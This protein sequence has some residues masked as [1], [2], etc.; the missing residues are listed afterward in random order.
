[1]R[2]NS[3]FPYS[4]NVN[5]QATVNVGQGFQAGDLFKF[6]S[7]GSAIIMYTSYVMSTVEWF[8]EGF[9][10]Q[11]TLS[12]APS[13][14]YTYIGTAKSTNYA[15][16]ISELDSADPNPLAFTTNFAI[17]MSYQHTLFNIQSVGGEDLNPGEQY[18][19][20]DYFELVVYQEDFATQPDQEHHYLTTV[21]TPENTFNFIEGQ[22]KSTDP[23]IWATIA[24]SSL[25]RGYDWETIDPLLGSPRTHT[26]LIIYQIYY[27]FDVNVQQNG[28]WYDVE[29]G[30]DIEM[31]DTWQ[32][33]TVTTT[34]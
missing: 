4:T 13:N 17:K 7:P 5:G 27:T 34:Y 2:T 31:F 12:D 9:E 3:E 28:E 25:N 30:T 10:Y 23:N 18:Q 29:E 6:V 16:D 15:T 22:S 33:L 24:L 19:G 1:M 32:S 26:F 20:K 8:T 21:A 14:Y 11:I